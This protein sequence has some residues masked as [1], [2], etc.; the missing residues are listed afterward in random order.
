MRSPARLKTCIRRHLP[1]DGRDGRDERLGKAGEASG[2]LT[3]AEY[4]PA[5]A[6]DGLIVE[7]RSLMT[8][9]KLLLLLP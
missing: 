1:V 4:N 7:A 6:E 3:V 5:V 9:M 2:R 8:A